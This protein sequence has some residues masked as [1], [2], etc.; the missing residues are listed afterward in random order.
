MSPWILVC[1]PLNANLGTPKVA[2]CKIAD[3]F[4]VKK[5]SLG[6]AEVS[7]IAAS[8]KSLES[9]MIGNACRELAT[10]K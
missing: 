7:L 9:S 3:S 8:M 10:S 6:M 1:P 2:L 4:A 5:A